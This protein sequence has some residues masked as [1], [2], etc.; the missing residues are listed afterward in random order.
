LERFTCF[1]FVK[2]SRIS[3]ARQIRKSFLKDENLTLGAVAI[4]SQVA[5]H[6]SN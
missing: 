1:S 5:D 3:E 2:F 6:T 4:G